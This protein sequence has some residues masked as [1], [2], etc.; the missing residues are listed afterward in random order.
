MRCQPTNTLIGIDSQKC[1]STIPFKNKRSKNKKRHQNPAPNVRGSITQY[2]ISASLDTKPLPEQTTKALI[3]SILLFI[4][5]LLIYQT[6][7]QK[8]EFY[9]ETYQRYHY[10]SKLKV[11]LANSNKKEPF[12]FKKSLKPYI[13]WRNMTIKYQISFL[14]LK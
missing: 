11:F 1:W 8:F 5:K 10:F 12:A 3:I 2:I 9:S 14:S 7:V 13:L 4:F 6:L